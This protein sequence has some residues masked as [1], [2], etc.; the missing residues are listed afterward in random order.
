MKKAGK[1]G[2]RRRTFIHK[3]FPSGSRSL[4]RIWILGGGAKVRKTSFP[5]TPRESNP[6]NLMDQF[7]KQCNKTKNVISAANQSAKRTN[8]IQK[9]SLCMQDL[10]RPPEVANFPKMGT[11]SQKG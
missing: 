2:R 4:A 8:I 5:E 1:I 3:G 10:P 7:P 9:A 11:I 6:Q